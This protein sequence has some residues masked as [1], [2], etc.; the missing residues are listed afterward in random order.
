MNNWIR[1]F[2]QNKLLLLKILEINY[3]KINYK[4]KNFKML[5]KKNLM[6]IRILIKITKNPKNY[7]LVRLI[8]FLFKFFFI[9]IK[10]LFICFDMMKV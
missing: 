8:I 5:I 7:W 4:I 1:N 9:A 10:F 3:K 6:L 2:R